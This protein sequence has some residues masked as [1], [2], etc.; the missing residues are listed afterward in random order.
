[1][2]E[3]RALL[4]DAGYG[5]VKTLLASGN[6]ILDADGEAAE[7]A[8][9]LETLVGQRFGYAARILVVSIEEVAAAV[10]SYPFEGSDDTHSYVVFTEDEATAAELAAAAAELP[11]GDRVQARGRLLFWSVA[12]GSTLDSPF[13]KLLG[14]R[15]TAFTTTRN[16][17]TLEKIVA[18]A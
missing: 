8:A 14:K 9:R 15:R 3:L 4:G 2:A 10:R 16:I 1:M 12:V 18:A 13:G 17:R 11:E 6:V 5:R 7:V